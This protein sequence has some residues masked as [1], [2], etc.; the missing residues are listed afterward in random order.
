MLPR[1]RIGIMGRM[2]ASGVLLLVVSAFGFLT[3]AGF[4]M[5]DS[6]QA[7]EALVQTFFAHDACGRYAHGP[8]PAALAGMPVRI[9][10]VDGKGDVLARSVDKPMAHPTP[11]DLA[12]ARAGTAVVK[13]G[14]PPMRLV[15]CADERYAIVGGPLG[16]PPLGSLFVAVSAMVL[17][18]AIG[19]IPLARS[20]VKP[21]RSL[22]ATA[23]K[24]GEGDLTARAALDRGDEIG[25]LAAAFDGMADKLRARLLAEK[26]LLANVSHELRTPLARVRV[27]LET[28]KE[29]P[30]RS[31][32]L[33]AE[34]SRDLS[35]L[36]RLTDDVLAAIRLDFAEADG[37]ATSF[38]IRP[39]D[40]DVADVLARAI[41]RAI[42]ARPEREMDL[43]APSDLP[44][45][46]GD[47]ALLLRLFDNLLDN[48]QKYSSGLTSVRAREEGGAIVVDVTDHGIG[49]DKDDLERIFEPFF[50]TD[51]SR[52]RGTGGTGLGLALCKRIADE[53]GGTIRATSTPGEGTT[54]R[55]T[56]PL[57]SKRTRA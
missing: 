39:E 31:E 26:E 11:A 16:D 54:L 14:D 47:S 15:A 40:V 45:L 13:T 53:H 19:S 56:L 21:I 44:R 41:T 29:D 34:I 9:A 43:D 57:A 27:V 46:R 33:L 6:A 52:Q 22:V 1:L 25:E 55:V 48:A 2:V 7:N 24:I 8:G 3:I 17:V 42:E 12:A 20:F 38:R 37:G 35:D 10:I 32:A 30:T 28:A 23:T 5:K 4:L 36:E 51:R 18:V 50:R 49:V